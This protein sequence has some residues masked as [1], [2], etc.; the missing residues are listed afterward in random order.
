MN[1][2]WSISARP[3]FAAR[4]LNALNKE[5]WSFLVTLLLLLGVS[6][7][8]IRRIP[9]TYTSSAKL[10]IEYPRSTEQ[11]TGLDAE[12]EVG[13]LDAV[14]ERVNPINNQVA[15]LGSYTVYREALTQLNL[16]EAEFPYANLTV[17]NIP[18]T[19][20]IQVAYEAA[21]PELAAQITQAVVTVYVQENLLSNRKKGSSARKFLETRLPELQKQLEQAQDRLE[22]F[23]SQN[24]FLGTT[25]ETDAL[26][27]SLTNLKSQ[28]NAAKVQLAFTEQKAAGLKAQLPNNLEVAVNSAGASQDVGYQ[29]LQTK[30][31]EAET[32]LAQLQVRLTD[33]NPQV[34][35]ARQT[36]DQIKALLQ[37]Q[38]ASLSP[39]STPSTVKPV[40]PLRQRLIE[41]WVGLETERAAQASQL[42]QL[43]QQL[44][45]TQALSE[46][47]P[48]LIKQQNQLQTAVEAAQQEY[49]TF[50]E[51][52]TTSQIAEQQ[53]ISNVRV[54]EAAEVLPFPTAP[55]RKLLYAIALVV[56]TGI[57]LG[58]VW[59][60]Q[61]R[62]DTIEGVG[63][64]RE[65]LPLS[66]LATVPWSGDGLLAHEDA[67]LEGPLAQSY[68]LLQA[69][70]RMLPQNIQV[71]AIC[72]GVSTE[73]RSS[74]ANN[75]AAVEALA[76]QRV[77]LIDADGRS[78]ERN[79]LNNFKASDR[80]NKNKE[81]EAPRYYK[82]PSN[83]QVANYDVLSS[84]D[85][86]PPFLYKEWLAMLEQRRQQYDLIIVDCPPALDS[87]DATV[88]ASMC[89][90]VLWVVCPQRLGRKGA[91]ACAENLHTWGTRLLGQ[92]VVG[93]DSQQPPTIVLEDAQAAKPPQ[94]QLLLQQ[95]VER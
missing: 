87:P 39:N 46:R 25:V 77:L 51:K 23:Q 89:D 69:H 58:V 16:S 72:S 8:L 52:Y 95:E 4:F 40:D 13:K 67:R 2:E 50:K 91:A 26:T 22:Q 68:Q 47:L 6:G 62:N 56:S 65:A 15:L 53:N 42:R 34:I 61:S 83:H 20:V 1:T 66:V 88:I 36:R 41:Q 43:T 63:E 18:T 74:V 33:E 60:L 12:A 10:L 82:S 38:S 78:F 93:V 73:G 19:D 5:R 32:L 30:L 54:V 55:N 48:Q 80:P 70:I 64:L 3:S 29:Q 31:L 21:S 11:L 49:L 14:G 59:L 76:G 9:P 35:S 86:P 27:N 75:L 37:Q 84:R 45:Q 7:V 90:G 71:I 17:S 92:V 57:S 85:V 79:E 81:Q 24:R 28:V 44:N 94:L